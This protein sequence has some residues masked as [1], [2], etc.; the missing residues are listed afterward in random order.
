MNTQNHGSSQHGAFRANDPLVGKTI[1]G[2]Y[3]I[4]RLIGR[5]GVGLVYLA[6]QVD[7]A[8]LV[9][10]KVLAPD[11]AHNREALARFEREV[12]RLGTLHHPNIVRMLDYGHEDGRGYMVMEYVDGVTLGQYIR[13]RGAL[14]LE[15]FVPIAAQILKGIGYAHSRG[16]IHRDLKPS[17]L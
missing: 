1:G 4:L 10:I 3:T 15:R 9:V 13:Q 11:W 16:M 17:N 7:A 12:E 14:E 2:R 5:G 6:S 8:E